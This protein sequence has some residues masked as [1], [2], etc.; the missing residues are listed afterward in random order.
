MNDELEM[1]LRSAFRHEGLPVAPATL[2]EALDA[3]VVEP[4]RPGS[5]ARGAA[6]R[7]PWGVLAVAAVLLVGGAVALSVGNRSPDPAPSPPPTFSPAPTAETGTRFTYEPRWT[8]ETPFNVD[9]LAAIVAIAQA[10]VDA[11]GVV[12]VV[13]STDDAGRVVVDVPAGVDSDPIRSLVGTTG[14]VAFVPGGAE[15][16]DIGAHLDRAAFPPLVD[17]PSIEDATRDNDSTGLPEML[18]RLDSDAAAVLS[19]YTAAHVG[20]WLALT[21]D[22]V[23]VV[24]P[25]IGDRIP[26]GVLVISY[27][28]QF[29]ERHDLDA[30]IAL[31]RNGPLPVPLVE[32]SSGPAPSPIATSPAKPSPEGA[33]APVIHCEPPLDVEGPQLD[34]DTAVDQALAILPAGHPAIAEV[35]FVHECNDVR[36]QAIPDC[37]VQMFGVVSVTFV[38][39]SPPVRIGLSLG[40]PPSIIP[41]LPTPSG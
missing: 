8:V 3:V 7:R 41:P 36:F 9:D 23:V 25:I 16:V 14:A 22:N 27:G 11:T 31:I 1:R 19:E 37:A 35:T 33:A 4:I 24:A 34:C 15:P 6:R 20:E 2:L 21:I 32:I 40:S 39:G 29:S 17:G 38:D 26:D 18:I 28:G 12:G 10:R 13:V 30:V 5:A